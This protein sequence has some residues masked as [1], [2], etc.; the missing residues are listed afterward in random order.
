MLKITL[1]LFTLILVYSPPLK[2]EEG[3]TY[4]FGWLDK[5]KEVYVLQGKKFQK[6]RSFML[7]VGVGATW[8]NPFVSATV[9]QGRLSYFFVETW[10]LEFL[11]SKANGKENN[12]ATDLQGGYNGSMPGVNPFIR[13]IDYYWALNLVWSPFYSKINLFD[14]IVYMDIPIGLGYVSVTEK[15]NAESVSSSSPDSYTS[16][17]VSG[18]LFEI[19]GLFYLSKVFD[20]RIDLIG[21]NYKDKVPNG[22]GTT[23]RQFTGSWNLMVGLGF[24]I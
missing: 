14:G 12:N 19:S 5:D 24:R 17:M 11:G 15:T 8:S 23:T 16:A 6:A 10:G 7:D 3:S 9:L 21:V 22:N 2:A 20:I 4:S 1:G 13:I 18:F